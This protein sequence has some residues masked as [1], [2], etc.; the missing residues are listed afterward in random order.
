MMHSLFEPFLDLGETEEMTQQEFSKHHDLEIYRAAFETAMQV[1]VVSRELPEEE[2]K[3]LRLQMVRSCRSV[4]ANIAEAWQKRRYPAAFVAK[5]NEAEAESAETWIEFA[6]RCRYVD[7]A[8]GCD[9]IRQ[10]NELLIALAQMI[11][12]ADAWTF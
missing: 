7:E 10:Y 2:R 3:L 11:Q 5:L 12:N 4:C 8:I 6:M 1:F 9:I